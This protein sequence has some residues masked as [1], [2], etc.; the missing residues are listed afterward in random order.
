MHYMHSLCFYCTDNTKYRRR[1]LAGARHITYSATS[2][3]F[4]TSVDTSQDGMK[5][6]ALPMESFI[7]ATIGVHALACHANEKE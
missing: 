2:C 4:H 7:V 5:R 1:Q 6:V 3:I